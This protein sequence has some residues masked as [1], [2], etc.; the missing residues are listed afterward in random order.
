MKNKSMRI[1]FF[2]I[3]DPEYSRNSV[4][5]SGF[6]QNGYSVIQC[7]VDPKIKK[8]VSKYFALLKEYKKI[9]NEKFDFVVVAT[10]GHSVVWL[11]KIVFNVPIV[12]DVFVS[13]YNSAVEDRK[14]YKKFSIG[15]LYSSFLDW[16]SC[17]TSDVILLDTEAH[18]K[19]FSN[20]YKIPHEKFVRVYV[21]SN[22]SFVYP[23][24]K[25]TD[26]KFIVHF[27]GTNI[28]LQGVS[29]ILRS[30]EI[31]KKYEDIQ[32]NLYG[33]EGT[34][35]QN[36]RFFTRFPYRDISKV[37][38]QAD[39]VLGIFGN[40]KKTQMVIPNKVFEG[41]AVKRAVLTARTPAISELLEDKNN[42]LLCNHNDPVDLSEKILFLKKESALREQI[43][44]F[45]YEL[46][47]LCLR[48]KTIVD[49]FL[50]QYEKFHF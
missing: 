7:R 16:F 27:H 34:N 3:Y 2:G 37:L 9:K 43:A 5:I 30:A 42:V 4:L 24:D 10:P 25:K 13:L 49:Q 38:S 6:E 23:M 41:L 11:A 47:V 21:G 20:R 33:I 32:Y 36:V 17:K 18:I 22:D 45:G 29:T 46:F 28:P 44:N 50:K 40:S 48:P 39:V 8:G 14:R 31:L 1:C 26:E 35:T 19:Y 15:S 12:F